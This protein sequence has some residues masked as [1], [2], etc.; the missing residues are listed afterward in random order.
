MLHMEDG[1]DNTSVAFELVPVR[2]GRVA[3]T[4]DTPLGPFQRIKMS[5]S[6]TSGEGEAISPHAK[7]VAHI[8]F[9]K[10]PSSSN[11]DDDPNKVVLSIESLA[12]PT[13]EHTTSQ[14]S[15]DEVGIELPPKT[16]PSK[17]WRQLGDLEGKSVVL[18]LG[19]KRLS[20]GV[21]PSGSTLLKGYALSQA[22]LSQPAV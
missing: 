16:F 7:A 19:F 18:Q 8:H 12:L 4:T 1:S 9:Q 6:Q 2:S 5:I 11:D 22:F 10:D 15:Y 14:N 17:E 13:V 21:V 20:R 3:A